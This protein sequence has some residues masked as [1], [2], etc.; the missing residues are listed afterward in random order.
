MHC[1]N[2]L[3]KTGL[4]RLRTVLTHYQISETEWY[5]GIRAGIYPKPIKQGRK[6]FWK[7]EDIHALIAE[8]SASEEV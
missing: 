4:V 1:L 5:D 2:T 3:P 8:I 7:A 6:S